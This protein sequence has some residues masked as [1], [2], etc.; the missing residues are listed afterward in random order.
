MALSSDAIN[1]FGY[2]GG[3]VIA[4]AAPVQLFMCL[5]RNSTDDITYLWLAIFL[6]GLTL[7]MCYAL[8][9]DLMP[10]WIPLTVEISSTFGT[11]MLKIYHNVQAHNKPQK[12]TTEVS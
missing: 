2:A 12:D 10:I 4:S 6:G 5:K 11:L 1:A 3:A 8:L 7:L 9:L